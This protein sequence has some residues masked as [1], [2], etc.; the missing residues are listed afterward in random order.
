M[1]LPTEHR[2]SHEDR[3]VEASG[4][5]VVAERLAAEAMEELP[6][7]SVLVFD[8]DYR[9]QAVFGAAV[10]EHG[11]DPAKLIGR[12]APEA[13]PPAAWERL[14]PL[15]AKATAGDTVTEDITSHDGTRI[16]ETTFS[17][18]GDEADY[19]GGMVVARDVTAE[20]GA[21]AALEES[22]R[23]HRMLSE[24]SGDVVSRADSEGRYTYVSAAARRLYG[25][26]PE[27]MVGRSAFEFIHPD[28]QAVTRTRLAELVGGAADEVTAEYRLRRSDGDWLWVEGRVKTIR[29]ADG[30][31]SAL[32]AA[33]RDITER[34]HVGEQLAHA[35]EMFERAFTFAPIGMA[36]VDLDGRWL[37][38]NP[39]L[40]K[41]TGHDE[42]ALMRR[43]L[44]EVTHI[45]DRGSG[46]THMRE[47]LAGG[48][49]VYRI[50]MR[51]IHADGQPVWAQLSA[52][53]VRKPDTT[54]RWFIVQIEDISDRKELERRLED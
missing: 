33:T 44:F 25:W 3:G 28:D 24:T 6:G 15:Y 50:D 16:Y 46:R 42:S 45:E 19:D 18:V 34:R 54:P 27:E 36:L 12:P 48:R 38:V 1:S 40:C 37:K 30:T 7:V 52:S 53:L 10:R 11:Y 20:R 35:K 17:P 32:Q 51:L 39:A 4:D 29:E 14:A 43:S 13:V 9:F 22:E 8:R 41:I 47:A 2:G 5:R 23:L 49:P 26:D 21:V 31:I